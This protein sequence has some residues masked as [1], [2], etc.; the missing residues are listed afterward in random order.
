[1]YNTCIVIFLLFIYNIN[2]TYSGLLNPEKLQLN[3]G[4][5]K[6]SFGGSKKDNDIYVLANEDDEL[7]ENDDRSDDY[8]SAKASNFEKGILSKLTGAGFIDQNNAPGKGEDLNRSKVNV[9]KDE[10]S[11]KQTWKPISGKWKERKNN[12]DTNSIK[13]LK[14][15]KTSEYSEVSFKSK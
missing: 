14:T 11:E 12:R 10:G 15:S 13:D 4:Q 1:M 6:L 8:K 7:A 9:I 3:I 2:I 5:L